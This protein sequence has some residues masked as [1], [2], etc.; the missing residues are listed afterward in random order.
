M[1]IRRKVVI[2]MKGLA[3]QYVPVS[4]SVH[5]PELF[6]TSKYNYVVLACKVLGA[7]MA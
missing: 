1:K 7:V 4:L 3:G 2:I 5:R 6:I